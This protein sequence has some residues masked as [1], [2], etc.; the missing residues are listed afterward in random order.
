[1]KRKIKFDKG[2]LLGMGLL[3]SLF[4]N[5][6]LLGKRWW[7]EIPR[8]GDEKEVAVVTKVIDGDTFNMDNG[9]RVRLLGVDAPEYPKG[10]LSKKAKLRLEELVLGKRTK[11]IYSSKDVFGRIVAWVIVDGL[12]I[13]KV[14]AGEGLGVVKIASGEEE[15][16]GFELKDEE[17]E[18][19]KAKRGIWSSECTAEQ[20][21][22]EIKGNFHKGT[23][24]RVY[25]LPDCYNYKQVNINPNEGDRW[26]CTENEAEE[27]GFVK[28]KDCPGMK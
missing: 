2:K 26:F 1:M 13:N 7:S 11:L 23:K 17:T 8:G 12:N 28:T 15:K 16:Y 4:L 19:K 14:M 3:V 6:V 18:A 21:G 27:A 5:V 10:C 9:E 25:H 24:D 20:E 22:C